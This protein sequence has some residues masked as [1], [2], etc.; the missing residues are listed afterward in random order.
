MMPA[1]LAQISIYEAVRLPGGNGLATPLFE[2]PAEFFRVFSWQH[3]EAGT[4][5]L[6]IDGQVL[7]QSDGL[8]NPF[9]LLFRRQYG[10]RVLLRPAPLTDIN[11]KALT[12]DQLDLTLTV[13]VNFM[14]SDPLKVAAMEAPLTTLTNVVAG[15]TAEYIRGETLATIVK[16]DSQLRNTLRERLN[17]APSLREAFEVI[18]VLK[19][20]PTGDERLI[21][22]GR[23]TRAEEARR[24]LIIAQGQNRLADNAIN[25]EI[26]ALRAQLDEQ[27]KEADHR[28]AMQLK[29]AEVMAQNFQSMAAAIA[30]ASSTG[31]DGGK[32]AEMFLKITGKNDPLTKALPTLAQ[33]N[34][35]ADTQGGT[36]DAVADPDAAEEDE[37]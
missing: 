25:H 33:N 16:D 21:E 28:R 26:A 23:E 14:V 17:V 29:E 31:A 19:A 24:S 2:M 12:S 7:R 6:I 5:V 22:I 20:I 10:R 13:S 35:P 9:G 1:N 32:L 37:R 18:E 34:L 4:E 30:L 15:L 27:R 36:D 11:A 3:V 8:V